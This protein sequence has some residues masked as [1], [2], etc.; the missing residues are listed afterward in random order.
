MCLACLGDFFTETNWVKKEINLN[1]SLIY[2]PKAK[3][4]FEILEEGYIDHTENKILCVI[5]KIYLK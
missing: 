3:H 5:F 2:K 4:F 1:F